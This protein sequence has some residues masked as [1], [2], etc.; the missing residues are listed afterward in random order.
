MK[1][2]TQV[3]L[4]AG[5]HSIFSQELERTLVGREFVNGKVI[6]AKMIAPDEIMLTVEMEIP[7]DLI[8]EI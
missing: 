4:Y 5:D 6:A 1:I 3:P 7:D 2:R 8:K